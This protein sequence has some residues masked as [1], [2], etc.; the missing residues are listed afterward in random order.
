MTVCALYVN[1]WSVRRCTEYFEI[2]SRLAFKEYDVSHWFREL[3]GAIPIVSSAI[4]FAISVLVDSKYSAEHLE[5]IQRDVYDGDRSIVDS[6]SASEMG[7]YLGVTLTG[8]D[9]AS[10]YV[11]TNYNGVGK[12]RRENGR[13]ECNWHGYLR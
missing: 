13:R 1:G 11:V 2:S 9:D 3:F 4:G 7:T 10:T 8:T 5:R 12:S 6:N